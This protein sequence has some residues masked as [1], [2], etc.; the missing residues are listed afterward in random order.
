MPN[1]A[2]YRIILTTVRRPD[3]GAWVAAQ[4][5]ELPGCIAEGSSDGDAIATLGR[6]FP[7]YIDSLRAD[8]V[9]VPE[10]GEFSVS[11]DCEPVWADSPASPTTTGLP[12]G[13][14]PVAA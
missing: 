12:F 11:L 3:G 8:G 10:P 2:D 4:V 7:D 5:A 9:P 6:I 1:L 13:A 14:H